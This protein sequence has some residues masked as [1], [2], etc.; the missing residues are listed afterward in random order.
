MSQEMWAAHKG[1]KAAKKEQKAGIAKMLEK[2][3]GEQFKAFE[4]MFLAQVK[5]QGIDNHMDVNQFAQSINMLY[6]TAQQTKMN[7]HLENINKNYLKQQSIA[8][9]GYLNKM[10]EYEGSEFTFD[11]SPQEFQFT[12]PD[13][14]QAAQL[15]IVDA[16]GKAVT[17]FPISLEPGQKGLRKWSWDGS[18][19]G[20]PE[21]QV[22]QGQYHAAI[23]ATSKEGKPIDV[24]LTLNGVVRKIG[25]HQ[26]AGEFA[27]LVKNTAIE[28]S[29]IKSSS[30]MPSS[31]LLMLSQQMHDQMKKYDELRNYLQQ[32]LGASV[33]SSAPLA[34]NITHKE[35]II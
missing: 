12:L 14:V 17:A 35:N 22:G 29:D 27:L 34:E 7:E 5:C 23:V 18:L 2:T 6:S 24:P 8:A 19:F 21:E 15:N 1:L 10:V 16:E 33:S 25:Y 32:N 3:N 9:K 13:D 28:F 4:K 26:E 11:G 31:E 30:R 20:H